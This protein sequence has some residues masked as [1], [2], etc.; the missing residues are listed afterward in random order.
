[1]GEIDIK[2]K[3]FMSNT[4]RFADLFNYLIYN[5]RPVIRP[6][7]LTPLDTNE[8]AVPNQDDPIQRFR[9]LIKLWTIMRDGNAIYAVLGLEAQMKVHYAMA[10]RA[11]VADALNYWQQVKTISEKRRTDGSANDHYLSG[12]GKED[13][14]VPVVTLVLYLG[15]KPWDGAKDVFGMLESHDAELMRFVSNYTMNLIEPKSVPDEDLELFRTGI[16][17]LLEFIKISDDKEKLIAHAEQFRPVDPDTVEMINLIT[18]AGLKYEVKEGKVD[19]CKAIQEL[20]A[21]ERAQGEAK[22]RAEGENK[23]AALFAELF[24]HGRA[25]DA[26]KAAIDPEYREKLYLEFR[27]V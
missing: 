15:S 8:K 2:M 1:M 7:A 4:E 26:Q 25:M 13:R 19:M 18:D 14:I 22:G 9:D 23:L 17:D 21:E 6:D 12:F 27:I 16:G 10:L 20:R 3:L 11:M 5:G 24:S